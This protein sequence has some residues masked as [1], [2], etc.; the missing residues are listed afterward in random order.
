[1]DV[2]TSPLDP[3]FGR[4]I[5]QLLESCEERGA[6]V[7]I[8]GVVDDVC[9][10][11]EVEG[12]DYLGPGQRQRE[13]HSIA[14]WH[15]GNWNR[16]R[17]TSASDRNG[18]RRVGERRT[19]KV[20]ERGVGH[21]MVDGPKRCRHLPRCRNFGGMALAI[22]HGERITGVAAGTRFSKHRRRIKAAGE[23]HHRLGSTGPPLIVTIL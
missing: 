18:Q 11:K 13:Q 9:P 6:A 2:E 15:V 14:G 7:G 23:E 8:P 1:M 5:G 20:A 3:R 22:G 19:A 12:S 21:A 17:P 10:N 16:V 4:Q